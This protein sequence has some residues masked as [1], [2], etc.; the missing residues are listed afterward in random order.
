MNKSSYF[1]HSILIH[2]LGAIW[3]SHRGGALSWQQQELTSL[4]TTGKWTQSRHSLTSTCIAQVAGNTR[5]MVTQS[6]QTEQQVMGKKA[7]IESWR[8]KANKSADENLLTC[9]AWGWIIRR[10]KSPKCLESK[11]KKRADPNV[12]RLLQSRLKASYTNCSHENKKTTHM[13]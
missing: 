7:K 12:I 13:P 6:C 8:S 1:C 9:C 2:S 5:K 11:K 3:I 10:K 4:R